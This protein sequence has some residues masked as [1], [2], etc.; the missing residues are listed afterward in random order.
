[1]SC[2][3][4]FLRQIHNGTCNQTHFLMPIKKFTGVKW[5]N[6]YKTQ[7]KGQ[8]FKIATSINI[9]ILRNNHSI[10]YL[11]QVHFD[12]C[13]FCSK[14]LVQDQY[15]LACILDRSIP[16]KYCI[17][18]NFLYSCNLFITTTDGENCFIAISKVFI[19]I[20]NIIFI[21]FPVW[22]PCISC[23]RTLAWIT[24]TLWH[25]GAKVENLYTFRHIINFPKL[26]DSWQRI[27]STPFKKV[28]QSD[29]GMY[30]QS[31]SNMKQNDEAGNS[32]C[33]HFNFS[34][35]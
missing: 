10:T 25:I 8:I 13:S 16:H 34:Q 7:E 22:N 9:N 31:L 17:L 28:K 14:S 18:N 6:T 3:L 2:A 19:F 4:Y 21:I 20:T 24:I 15:L 12:G 11:L 26:L 32:L 29:F 27:S 35:F 1:M 33:L 30:L 23:W 5:V